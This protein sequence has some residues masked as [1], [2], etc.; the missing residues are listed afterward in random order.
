MRTWTAVAVGRWGNKLTL[1]IAARTFLD[2]IAK[3]RSVA[4]RQGHK[5]V[6]FVSLVQTAKLDA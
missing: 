6:R 1:N 4:R 3:V 2:A 5:R